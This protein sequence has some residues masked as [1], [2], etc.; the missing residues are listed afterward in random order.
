M[1]RLLEMFE[2]P[3]GGLSSTRVLFVLWFTM[4]TLSTAGLTIKDGKF[5]DHSDTTV[6]ISMSLLGQ[7]WLQRKEEGKNEIA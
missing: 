6:M 2:E 4:L 5:P 7:K 1:K 3:N